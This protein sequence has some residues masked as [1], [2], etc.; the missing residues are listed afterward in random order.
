MKNFIYYFVS[1]LIVV[2]F[3]SIGFSEEG[4]AKWIL[5]KTTTKGPNFT[6][7]TEYLYDDNG[8]E[9]QRKSTNITSNAKTEQTTSI[10]YDESFPIKEVTITQISNGVTQKM[11]IDIENNINGK[12]EKK[13][14]TFYKNGK[15]QRQDTTM[16]EYDS[17]GR[18][19]KHNSIITNTNG[20]VVKSMLI[21]EYDECGKITKFLSQ[22]PGF[23]N[24]AE[25]KYI[26]GEN[27]RP[28]SSTTIA[29]GSILVKKENYEYDSDGNLI[30]TNTEQYG[31]DGKVS[32]VSILKTTYDQNGKA[33][34]YDNTSKNLA[35][36]TVQNFI[37]ELE[38]I[39][40]K[41]N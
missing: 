29:N 20:Q 23:S 7:I 5:K 4:E 39:K 36:N 24:L 35:N 19:T 14:R 41:S 3:S 17:E 21:K 37:T 22:S 34:R 27:C 11:E 30:V 12:P 18:D 8:K 28:K 38:F 32:A 15:K 26:Y 13:L 33:I 25:T 10:T 6:S 31:M 2:V 1:V 9:I 40:N 16:I